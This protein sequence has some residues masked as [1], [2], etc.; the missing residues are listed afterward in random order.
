M[1][2]EGSNI[3]LILTNKPRSFYKTNTIETGLSDHHKLIVSFQEAI[4]A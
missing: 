4:T 2:V 1:S 3:D